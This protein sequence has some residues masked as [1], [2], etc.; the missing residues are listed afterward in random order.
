[1]S[2]YNC[3]KDNNDSY[4]PICINCQFNPAVMISKSDAKR[5]FKLS[6]CDLEKSDLFCI[7]FETIYY[8]GTKYLISDIINLSA[9]LTKNLPNNDKK[10]QAYLK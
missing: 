3:K 5:K 10:R 8:S 9:E 7:S 1:M 4:H 2:C 6:D